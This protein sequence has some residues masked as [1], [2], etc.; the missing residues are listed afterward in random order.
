MLFVNPDSSVTSIFCLASKRWLLLIF[1]TCISLPSQCYFQCYVMLCYVMLCYVM[2][3]TPI[4][5][6]ARV[7]IC[8]PT[9]IFIMQFILIFPVFPVQSP[10]PSSSS[11]SV[12]G[13]NTQASF[14]LTQSFH[15]YKVYLRLSDQCLYCT[16]SMGIL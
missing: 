13:V 5:N 6:L 1:R 2:L 14:D 3:C 10:S 4:I 9:F 15:F 16:I 12:R 7:V 8:L 11:S